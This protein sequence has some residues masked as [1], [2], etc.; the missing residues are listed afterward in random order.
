MGTELFYLLF[1]LRTVKIQ[2]AEE[3]HKAGEI[4]GHNIL[5]VG[6]MSD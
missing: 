4:I 5:L 3:I 1:P 6:N 2:R